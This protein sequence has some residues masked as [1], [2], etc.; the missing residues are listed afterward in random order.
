MVKRTTLVD[1]ALAVHVLQAI[2]EVPEEVKKAHFNQAELSHTLIRELLMADPKRVD[3]WAFRQAIHGQARIFGRIRCFTPGVLDAVRAL[4]GQFARAWVTEV[5]GGETLES[6]RRDNVIKFW[7]NWHFLP[8]KAV[9]LTVAPSIASEVISLPDLIVGS[10]RCSFDKAEKEDRKS[11]EEII[12]SLPKVQGLRWIV[13]NAPTVCRVLANHLEESGEYLLSG[14][15]TW[16]TDE[17][18]S[19]E[20]SRCR[21]VVGG[22]S[23]FGVSVSCFRPGVWR[24]VV[25]LFVLGVPE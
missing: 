3:V 19:P 20:Y 1:R 22:C 13:G 8:E 11:V 2:P 24:G 12:A 4:G 21:L 23:P 14:V 25:G 7:T 15:Y 9:C 17:Y 5:P 18:K 6:Q 10:L 16:T